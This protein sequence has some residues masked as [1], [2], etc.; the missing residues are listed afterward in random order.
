MPD[1]AELLHTRR[2]ILEFYAGLV[3]HLKPLYGGAVVS[4]AQMYCLEVIVRE[5]EREFNDR[6]EIRL[7]PAR[8]EAVIEDERARVEITPTGFEDRGAIFH[9]ALLPALETL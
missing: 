1:Y 6:H 9:H 2:L 5:Q 8:V 4:P 3:A 7:H